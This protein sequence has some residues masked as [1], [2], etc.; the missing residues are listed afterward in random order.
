M[1]IACNDVNI[2]RYLAIFVKQTC[3]T[4]FR[5]FHIPSRQAYLNNCYVHTQLQRK[6]GSIGRHISI[7]VKH[8]DC[9]YAKTITLTGTSQYLLNTQTVSERWPRYTGTHVRS[10]LEH[11]QI[12]MRRK[13]STQRLKMSN[14]SNA[15]LYKSRLF[16]HKTTM[17]RAPNPISMKS[18]Y[19]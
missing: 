6:G 3:H 12:S 11:G 14:D 17:H 18:K 5:W 9:R 2:G 10:S 16:G 13:K 4:Y 15:K 19:Y 1:Y 8:T 7:S